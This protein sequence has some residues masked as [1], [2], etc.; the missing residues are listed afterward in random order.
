MA[1]DHYVQALVEQL[2]NGEL[3]SNPLSVTPFYFP[4]TEWEW[5]LPAKEDD[6]SDEMRGSPEGLFPDIIGFGPFEATL[7]HRPYANQLGLIAF[8]CFGA[9]VTTAGN[10]VITDPD[11]ATIPATATRH[12]WDS[13]AL[14][15][16]PRSFQGT[17]AYKSAGGSD[18]DKWFRGKGI[19]IDGF[20]LPA[21][22]T[23]NAFQASAKGLYLQ[24]L[25]ADPTLS[26]TYD[27][28]TIKPFY[29]PDFTVQTWLAGTGIPS[30]GLNFEFENPVAE[31][32]AYDGSKYPAGF[33]L[34]GLGP[35]GK[36]TIQTRYL[37]VDDFDAFI[38]GTS[39]SIKARWK[40]SINIAAT[41]YKYSMWLEAN[42]QYSDFQAE[43]LK[44]QIRHGAT[45][46]FVFGKGA[47]VSA[48]KLTLVNGVASYSSV[49]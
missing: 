41:S 45:L 13:A 17:F 35:I 9:P 4:A 42:A 16:A 3:S 26:P 44:H 32:D 36:G 43:S 29:E 37:D 47:A 18:S 5:H 28:P 25:V 31:F 38:G 10:G 12:V 39:F 2:P 8:C 30:G 24:R 20:N 22:F 49:G 11:S 27:A 33:D 46:P 23:A 21:D 1:S 19:H 15:A 6:R 48:F 14:G 7:H 40:S 34:D